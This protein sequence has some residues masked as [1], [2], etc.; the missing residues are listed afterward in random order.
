MSYK[1]IYLVKT[2]NIHATQM[3][4][5]DQIRLHLVPTAGKWT[6]E[7]KGAKHIKVLRIEDKR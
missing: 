3:V 1:V 7:S 4:K 5:N 6:W 2:Y